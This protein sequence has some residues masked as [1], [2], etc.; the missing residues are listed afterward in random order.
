MFKRVKISLIIC[1]IF[2]LLVGITGCKE[3][4]NVIVNT[5]ELGRMMHTDEAPSKSSNYEIVRLKNGVVIY[6]DKGTSQSPSGYK[7]VSFSPAKSIHFGPSELK[8]SPDKV[9]PK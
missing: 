5:D 1:G 6:K 7:D 4:K 9:D 2:F 8:F 3:R